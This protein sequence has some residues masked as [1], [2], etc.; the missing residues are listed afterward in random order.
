MTLDFSIDRPG[1]YDYNYTA[2]TKLLY[3]TLTKPLRPPTSPFTFLS[4]TLDPSIVLLN[5]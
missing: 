5:S 3:L 1:S 2:P 4:L